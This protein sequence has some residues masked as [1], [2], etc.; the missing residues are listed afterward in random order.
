MVE[1]FRTLQ[2]EIALDAYRN[3]VGR[4]IKFGFYPT[5][6]ALMFNGRQW[7]LLITEPLNEAYAS[8]LP[9]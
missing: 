7:S 1:I 5:S 9:F 4:S 3:W 6:V 8:T 2:I